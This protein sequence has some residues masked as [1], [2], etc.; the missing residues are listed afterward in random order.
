[1]T[2][3]SQFLVP[4]GD[5]VQVAMDAKTLTRVTPSGKQIK[6]TRQVMPVKHP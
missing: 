5:A 1:M 4:V 2:L 3:S 6:T